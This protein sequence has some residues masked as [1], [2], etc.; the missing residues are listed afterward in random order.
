MAGGIAAAI[1]GVIF[2]LPALRMRGLY[3][4]LITLMIAGGFQVFINAI[5]FPD[6]GPGFTGKVYAGVRQYMPHPP[7]APSDGA[8]FRYVV[9]VVAVGFVIV[10]LIQRSRAG[11]AWA[12]IRRSE[13]VAVAMGVNI[14]AYK[15]VAFAIAGLLRRRR[16]RALMAA[17]VGQL[18]GRAFPA[19]DSIMMFAL[20]VIGGAF[21]WSGP[22]FAGLL[23][24][25]VP[26]LLTDWHIDGNLATMVFGAGLL[27]AL[28]TAP[29]GVSGQVVS[30]GRLIGAKLSAAMPSLMERKL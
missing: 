24:R 13:P 20:T 19:S 27:H 15:V 5:G 16:R 14:V 21:H 30:L 25:A 22:I 2:G 23:L 4:A 9:A 8:Y 12:L 29:Q 6:G 3:F 11:R 10:M 1:F 17:N 7:L 28:I 18:D 26:G